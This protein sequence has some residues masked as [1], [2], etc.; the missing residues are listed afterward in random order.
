MSNSSL[1]KN[2]KFPIVLPSHHKITQLLFK[3]EHIQLLH[4]GPQALLSHMHLSYWPL[5]GRNLSRMTVHKCITCFRYKPTTIQPFM[6]NLP[7]ER[8]ERPFARTGIDYC[9][10][11]RIKSGVRRVHQLSGAN[12]SNPPWNLR[13]SSSSDRSDV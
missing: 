13:N 5:R 3:Y 1:T 9:G 2:T 7:R 8:V 6:G 11:I 4:A 10:P 12:H